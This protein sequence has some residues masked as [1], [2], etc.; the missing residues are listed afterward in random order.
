M[1]DSVRCDSF[2]LL[3]Q[4]NS[5]TGYR[6]RWQHHKH[7]P[8]IIIITYYYYY[9]LQLRLITTTWI[10]VLLENV[11]KLRYLA[12]MLDASQQVKCAWKSL[13]LIYVPSTKLNVFFH[14]QVAIVRE[15]MNKKFISICYIFKKFAKMIE[16]A[17]FIPGES[18]C[19]VSY[20]VRLW[21]WS[22]E[23]QCQQTVTHVTVMWAWSKWDS[24][25]CGTAHDCTLMNYNQSA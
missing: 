19:I 21:D 1:T 10:L 24:E 14:V 23:G 18:S 11:D 13:R 22:D 7:C 3:V 6:S 9:C 5:R 25:F 2:T 8:G 4:V 17:I 16:G 20:W 12:A 15:K